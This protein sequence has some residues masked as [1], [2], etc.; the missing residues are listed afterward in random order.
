MEEHQEF[1]PT[2]ENG[3]FWEYYKDLERQFEDFLVFVPY[4]RGNEKTYSF[5]LLNIFLS[6][7]I[8]SFLMLISTISTGP[9]PTCAAACD[10]G[11][12][13]SNTAMMACMFFLSICMAASI[14]S[15]SWFCWRCGDHCVIFWWLLVNYRCIRGNCRHSFLIHLPCIWCSRI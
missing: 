5:K 8:S 3:G 2:F 6:Q 10:A 7:C 15:Q 13:L 9:S 14:P 1:N 12:R 11:S 4:L